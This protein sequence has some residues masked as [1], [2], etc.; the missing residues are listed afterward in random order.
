MRVSPGLCRSGAPT[1]SNRSSAPS[2]DDGRWKDTFQRHLCQWASVSCLGRSRINAEG[3]SVALT[4]VNRSTL[5]TN[6]QVAAQLRNDVKPLWSTRTAVTP[7]WVAAI[8]KPIR[9]RD[10]CRVCIRI[11]G[12]DRGPC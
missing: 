6:A 3:R 5:T 4:F 9:R 10:N 11:G 8:Y 2:L 12:I 1:H 7:G